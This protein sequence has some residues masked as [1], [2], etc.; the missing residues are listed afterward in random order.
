M[1]AVHASR[2]SQGPARH[3]CDSRVLSFTLR[4][5]WE[6]VEALFAAT[7]LANAKQK[8]RNRQPTAAD[9]IAKKTP[10]ERRANIGG[11]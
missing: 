7:A 11:K 2:R 5:V 4:W 10:Q 9:E 8:D 1:A 3:T 6:D